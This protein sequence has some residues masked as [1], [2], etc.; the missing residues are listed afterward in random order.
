MMPGGTGRDSFFVDNIGDTVPELVGEGTDRIF[1]TI[2]Y[3]VVANVENMTPNGSSAINETGSGL[4]NAMAANGAANRLQGLLG[5]DFLTG[6]GSA[7]RFVFGSAVSSI[8]TIPDFASGPDAMGMSGVRFGGGLNLGGTVSLVANSTPAAA[9]A[10][11]SGALRHRRR[12]VVL[13]RR[14]QR[15]QRGGTIRGAIGEALDRLDRLPDRVRYLVVRWLA[16]PPTR[17]HGLRRSAW[18]TTCLR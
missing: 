15:R 11:R 5:I 2:S 6:N 14:R 4:G 12:P 8:D 10:G 16:R 7:A 13:G 1:M 3:A 17:S 9:S 18:R